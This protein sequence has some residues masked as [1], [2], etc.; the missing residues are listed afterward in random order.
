[1]KYKDESLHKSFELDQVLQD[2]ELLKWCTKSCLSDT[3]YLMLIKTKPVVDL[4]LLACESCQCKSQENTEL[5]RAQ[6]KAPLLYAASVYSYFWEF[7][8]VQEQT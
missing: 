4:L 2:A 7:E 5:K 8:Q 6:A 3:S 1:M